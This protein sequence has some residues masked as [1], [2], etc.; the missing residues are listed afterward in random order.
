MGKRPHRAAARLTRTA[1]GLGIRIV[2]PGLAIA[3]PEPLAVSL[4][5][6]GT[7]AHEV[8]SYGP[9]YHCGIPSAWVS[10]EDVSWCT[11]TARDIH[12][13]LINPQAA[14]DPEPF[15][16]VAIDPADPPMYE[17][18]AAYRA[19]CPACSPSP[20]VPAPCR[21]SVPSSA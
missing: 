7:P 14:D 4:G 2:L 15:L 18:Q 3:A 16:G 6:T 11:G 13:E 17:S 19:A 20:T 1:D 21:R 9:A 10:P 5:G 8:L 12:G